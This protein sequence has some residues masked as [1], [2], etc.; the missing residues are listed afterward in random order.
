M[1]N[2]VPFYSEVSCVRVE[3]SQSERKVRVPR[4][5]KEADS[6]GNALGQSNRGGGALSRKENVIPK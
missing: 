5:S 3:H 2:H 4:R 6:Q 1:S